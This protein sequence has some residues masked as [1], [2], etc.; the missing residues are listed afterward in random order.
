VN[1]VQDTV[2]GVTIQ[3]NVVA[4]SAAASIDVLGDPDRPASPRPPCLLPHRQQYHLWHPTS[5]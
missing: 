3:N 5:S 1:N 2:G 4:G